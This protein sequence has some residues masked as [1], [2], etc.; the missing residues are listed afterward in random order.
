MRFGFLWPLN[1]KPPKEVPDIPDPEMRRLSIK[2]CVYESQISTR[3]AIC[4][5]PNSN[6]ARSAWQQACSS[7]RNSYLRQAATP[8]QALPTGA[9]QM[10]NPANRPSGE[11]G[12]NVG[13]KLGTQIASAVD[14]KNMTP[15]V[16]H[17]PAL[18]DC[19]MNS[20]RPRFVEQPS[21]LVNWRSGH[22]MAVAVADDN[23]LCLGPR[24]LIDEEHY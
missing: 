9:H 16:E 18:I 4:Q 14:Y 5:A 10:P 22:L 1:H 7:R 17:E 15:V 3:N 12:I 8:M 20:D 2:P 11:V 19:K 6:V 13:R 21:D 23:V 24:R